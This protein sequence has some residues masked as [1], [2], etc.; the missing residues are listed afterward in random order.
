MRRPIASI[1]GDNRAYVWGDVAYAA[2]AGMYSDCSLGALL[3]P[4][5]RLR[6]AAQTEFPTLHRRRDFAPCSAG[7]CAHAEDAE[8]LVRDHR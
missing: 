3:P 4:G 8:D 5:E 6:A 7:I 1:A 2:P